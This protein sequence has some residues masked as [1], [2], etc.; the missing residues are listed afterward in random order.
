M[1][2][3]RPMTELPAGTVTFLFTDI[4]GSTRLLHE[5][6]DRYADV[7][8]DH[9]RLL[10]EVFGRHNGREVDT[11]GDSFFVAFGDADDAVR[12]AAAAQGALAAHPW[13]GEADVRVRMGIHT[14]EPL[15]SGDH[16]VGIDVHR[17]AR[18]AAA[19]YGGQVL[20]SARTSAL[21]QGNGAGANAAL[22]ELGAYPLKDLPEPER[23]FQLVVE[24]LPA[25]FP[26]PRVDEKAPAAAGLP[27]Y[28]LPPADVPCP[29]KGLVRFEP[30]DS[31]LFFGREEIVSALVARLEDSA[32]LAVV[33]PSGSG[34]SS[35]VRAGLVPELERREASVRPAI[36]EPGEHPLANLIRRRDADL[37]VV[38]QFEEVFTLCRDEEERISFIDALLDAAEEGRRVIVALRADFYGHCASYGRLA[39]ALEEHQAL[40]GPMTEEEL[41]RAIERPAERAGLVL[42]PGLAEGI[43]RDVVG[44]PGALPLLSHSLLE[45][46]RRRSDRM[47]TLL[48]YLQ[49]GGVRGAIA[50]TAETVY[51]EALRP[52]QQTLA[53][54][55]FLRLTELGEGTEDTRRRARVGE[56]TPRREKAADVE[57]VL[58][59]LV[60]ARLIT[61]GEGTVE[62]AHEALIRHWPTLRAWLDEDREGRLVHRRLTEAAQEWETLG[63]EPGA[64]YRGARL[65]A[66]TE[67]AELHDDELNELEREFLSAGHEAELGEV[68]A[69]KRRNRRLRVLVAALGVLLLGA[70][71]AGAF[72]LIQRGNAREEAAR[73]GREARLA[74]ARELAAAA[75][76]N[77]N[78][79][80]ERSILLAR[81]AV[82]ATWETD[83]TTVPE[84]E[85]ALHRALKASRLVLTVP[86]GGGL[87]VSTDGRRFA[88][89]GQ[90]GTATVWKTATGDRLLRLRG[91]E[92]ALTG[93]AF[94][95]DGS[96][97]AT[98]GTD[99]SARVW[100]A[101]S[102]RQIKVLRG[103]R[104]AVSGVAFSPDGKRLATR[105][106]DATVRI[107]NVASGKSEMV[108]RGPA[109]QDFDSLGPP[110][111]P[112]FSPDGSQVA[113][114]GWGT[115]TTI[116]DSATGDIARVLP[117]HAWAITGIAF[118]PDG[119]HI[120]TASYEGAA[121][122]YAADSGQPLIT[123]SGHTGEL[124][125]LA[126]SPDGKR[127]ATGGSDATARVWDATTGDHLM[128]LAGHTTGIS[129]VRFTSD[130]NRLLTAGTDGT[131]RLWN[132]SLTGGRDWLT[133]PGPSLRI[134]GVAFSPDGRTFAVPEQGTGVTIRDADTGAKLVTLRGHD[135]IHARIAFSP[136]G[137]RLAA[138]DGTGVTNSGAN[139]TVPIWDVTTGELVTTL[140]GHEGDVTAVAF[141]PDGRRIATS[142][143]DGSLRIW[144]ATTGKEQR[145]FH[146]GADS[147]GLEFTP[148][149]RFLV[150]GIGCD[151]VFMV[152]EAETLERRHELRAH[153]GCVQDLAV[154]PGGT[155]VTAGLDGTAKIWDVE[156]G[157]ELASLRG[158]SGAVL[159]ASISP[160]GGRVATSSDDG[161]A[162]LWDAATGRELLTLFGHDR[163][164][165]SVA[166]SP[167]GR[168]LA[169]ASGD[170]TVALHLLPI[171]ALRNL[172]RQRVSRNL[173]D[174]ECRQYLHLEKCPAGT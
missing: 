108:L 159:D 52:A 152:W 113:S 77:L 76:A 3:E 140:I 71:A 153:T 110:V 1:L 151:G 65:A 59:V 135:A 19:A 116:W 57:E 13:P 34:K 81:E 16:Y 122:I 114:G 90:D 23:L 157:R 83:G 163:M 91:H 100:D 11:Q 174:E 32:F 130:G 138:A 82:D 79:D 132:V 103:H 2:T 55:I 25:S 142:G 165:H 106:D 69:T 6:G 58:R 112:A 93:I 24:G 4:E 54:N 44:E 39:A 148:D 161:T 105:G 31:D 118:S 78:V 7:L 117:G 36:I 67:W 146:V 115:T 8:T 68:E 133:V 149:G 154:G 170:G 37:V 125:S 12:A 48:G 147:Y 99:K 111:S 171:A 5:L 10:R 121:R 73:A 35:L 89:T 61:T 47:L 158:H 18:I 80:S 45:T 150:A 164:V 17:G 53:R 26:P 166:F 49:S 60:E 63:R 141:S 95:P 109:G 126:Y 160:D 144:D 98:T 56:L 136:D 28:S 143:Y 20:I 72:A 87:A 94:S 74:T 137:K 172:A 120:A 86:Q 40:I 101:S 155:V 46:W 145:A 84:A 123:L 134:G 43:L 139:R 9:R 29:Y 107:W 42:E 173:T 15:I 27:D 128:T 96:R 70:L 162:K 41:R 14:G 50:K 168:L 33:G 92:G 124:H 21:V 64:L 156:S 167:D 30:E 104:Q 127:I 62:V 66:A 97:L 88:T 75:V 51:R 102:G 169:T 22:R 119:R 131:K 38:D 129:H 85:E